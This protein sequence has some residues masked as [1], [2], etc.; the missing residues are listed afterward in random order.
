MSSALTTV[1][2]SYTYTGSFLG[3]TADPCFT[4]GKL[5]GSGNVYVNGNSFF[6]DYSNIKNSSDL[7][8]LNQF[9]G[10][11]T[12]GDTFGFTAGVYYNDTDGS[13]LNWNGTFQLQ[14]KT[15][16]Y[17][18]YIYCSG[19]CGTTAITN[20]YYLSNNFTNVI[21]FTAIKGTTANIFISNTPKI[22]PLNLEYMGIYGSNY[23]FEE[24]LEIPESS[25][26]AG[27]L[28]IKNFIKLNDDTE[29]VY[30]NPSITNENRYFNKSTVNL[31]YRGIPSLEVLAATQLDSGVI[32]LT[33][34]TTN[35][36]TMLL[37]NQNPYQHQC[38]QQQ[39]STNTY[40]YYPNN[41][42]KT[43]TSNLD[44]ITDY[45]NLSF[46]Y[47]AT[48]ILKYITT[49][50]AQYN[51]DAL[52]AAN[53]LGIAS[54]EDTVYVD[55]VATTTMYV[56]NFNRNLPLKI[57]ISNAE[58]QGTIVE[59]YLDY[60]CTQ[61]LRENYYFIG[62]PGYEGCSFIYFCNQPNASRTIFIKL[63]KNVS[64]TLQIS[65]T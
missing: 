28:K 61:L 30:L 55:D 3:A 48:Y 6:F 59:F 35:Q 21:Q 58:N 56:N 41:T 4:K 25:Y 2:T 62:T 34:N 9:F 39:D 40:Y 51:T 11:L 64:K 7:K 45:K 38:R 16:I 52:E 37:E 14:G 29:V 23:G 13:V 26:N 63:Q 36:N 46:S 42:L 65:L 53:Y 32:K 44:E 33:N 19:I 12:A 31:V 15:G 5:N 18:E 60:N 50:I 22:S 47:S 54:F 43:I 10:G 49:R 17:N 57:D 20:K 27:R 24:Y 8:F 1:K